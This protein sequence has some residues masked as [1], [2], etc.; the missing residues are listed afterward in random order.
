MITIDNIYIYRSFRG[1]MNEWLCLSCSRS[2]FYIHLWCMMPLNGSL[3][4]I[5]KSTME[6]LSLSLMWGQYAGHEPRSLSLIGWFLACTT[7]IDTQRLR[8][9]Y[10][11][12]GNHI[13][14]KSC[15]HAQIVS[16]FC[17][18]VRLLLPFLQ[19]Q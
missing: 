19:L 11:T 13:V 16:E 7:T 4:S 8:C 15:H 12:V 14:H 17:S 18:H 5:S 9:I 3:E 1:P 6:H 10:T 2:S